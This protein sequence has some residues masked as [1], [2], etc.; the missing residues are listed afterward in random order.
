[1][2]DDDLRSRR[3]EMFSRTFT[4]LLGRAPQVGGWTGYSKQFDRDVRYMP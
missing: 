2:P 3:P 1:M 4:W